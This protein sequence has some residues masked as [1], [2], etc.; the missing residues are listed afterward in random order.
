VK[1]YHYADPD[2]VGDI[3]RQGFKE[4]IIA[5]FGVLLTDTAPSDAACGVA[6]DLADELLPQW[7]L[8]ASGTAK[9][10]RVPA[11]LLNERGS[12]SSLVAPARP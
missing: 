2:T 1:L 3:L 12:K 5:P 11:R 8:L 10:W 4:P 7:A 9:F 6:V